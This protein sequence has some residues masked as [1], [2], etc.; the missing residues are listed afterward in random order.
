MFFLGLRA[1]YIM[2]SSAESN[3]GSNIAWNVVNIKRNRHG[4]R[5]E[6]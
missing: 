3:C 2:V 6:P 5:T 1:M 4:S